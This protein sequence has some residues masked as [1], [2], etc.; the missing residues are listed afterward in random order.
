M[1]TKLAE[2]IRKYRKTKGFTQEQLAEALGVTTGA[3]YK[4]ESEKSVP[5]ICMLI[6]LADFF[7]TSID[8]LLGY[9]LRNNDRNS[10]IQRLKKYAH[11][12]ENDN[13]F[14]EAEKALQK[15]PNCFDVVYRSAKIYRLY[16]WDLRDK[17]LS[18]RALELYEHACLLF[19]Q[20][21]DE[22][23]SLLEIKRDMADIYFYMDD[24]EKAIELWKKNN[25]CGINNAAI[26]G[27]LAISKKNLD[28][29]E[30]YISQ[31]MINTITEQI[32]IVTGY[33]NIYL[34][35]KDYHNIIN[36]CKWMIS[37]ISGLKYQ[38]KNS[39]IMKMEALYMGICAEMYLYLGENKQAENH[40]LEAKRIADAFDVNPNYDCESLKYIV[41]DDSASVH[42]NLGGTAM[43]VI[44]NFVKGQVEHKE[45]FDLWEKVKNNYQI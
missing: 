4:W 44:E 38:D 41:L 3:V 36:I 28:E 11:C 25:P 33:I 37:N 2:N 14:I 17:K 35:R 1:N 32:T 20:N 15:Y 31:A 13:A 9:E 42:D 27:A 26:G 21:T 43:E 45:L 19:E 10:T 8:A 29:G 12:R 22:E 7:D 6:E 18:K 24:T 30:K 16:G 40:M 5:E 23:I 39:Y 34:E